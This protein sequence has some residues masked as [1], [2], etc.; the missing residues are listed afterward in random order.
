MPS[1]GAGSC[2]GGLRAAARAAL[3]RAFGVAGALA[4]AVA[5]AALAALAAATAPPAGA[6]ELPAGSFVFDGSVDAVA[7]ADGHTYLGGAFGSQRAATGAGVVVAAGGDGAVAPASFPHVEGTVSA[8]IPDGAGGWY[9]GGRFTRVGGIARHNLA[10]ITVTGAVD[11]GWRPVADAV[12][13]DLALAGGRVY[14]AGGFSAVDD[15]ARAGLAAVDAD[16]GAVADWAPRLATRGYA[17]GSSAP[18]SA[19]AASATTVY[20]SGAFRAVDGAERSGGL[21]AFDAADGA[22]EPWAPR[23]DAFEG[24][25]ALAV[26]DGRLYAAGSFTTVDGVARAG[27]AAFD[28]ATGELSPWDPRLAGA[29]IAPP[30]D[31]P[32]DPPAGDAPLADPPLTTGVVVPTLAV[33][34]GTVYVAGSFA[35][36]GDDPRA[37]LAAIDAASGE[38]TAWQPT[39]G[40]QGV[41]ALAAA[42]GVVYLAGA[43]GTVDGAERV[44]AAAVDGAGGALLPWDPQLLGD[45]ATVAV[46][47]GRVYL[48]GTIAGAGPPLAQVANLA[49]LDGDGALDADWRPQPDGAVT[50]L[51]SGGGRLY[52]AGAFATIGGAARA[53][54]AALDP[55]TGAAAAWDPAPDGPVQALLPA[56]DRVYLAGDF[57]TVGGAVRDGL[58]AVA[59][60]SG[61]AA[62]WQPP[63]P[64]DGGEPGVVSQLA[65]GDGVV[66]V[67][68]RF[69]R[70]GDAARTDV[71]A[72]DAASGAPTAWDARIEQPAGG[73]R[74][75]L[76]SLAADDGAV[77][78]AGDFARLGDG[79]ERPGL[80]ALDTATGAPTAWEPSPEASASDEVPGMSFPP[81]ARPQTLALAGDALYLA[82]PRVVVR[83]GWWGVETR[84][85]ALDR[86]TGAV[87]AWHPG[88]VVPTSSSALLAVA[89][90]R[91][92]IAATTFSPVA[93]TTAASVALVERAPTA[94]TTPPRATVQRPQPGE[95]F[96]RGAVVDAEVACD[97]QGGTPLVACAA[98][99]RVDTAVSGPHRF[100]VTAQNAAG[101]AIQ[102]AVAYEVEPP[103][104]AGGPWGPAAA[105][106]APGELGAQPQVAADDAGR[107]TALYLA[108]AARPG[109]GV[110]ATGTVRVADRQASGAWAEPATLSGG[111]PASDPALAAGSGG[112]RVAAWV[113]HDGGG[114]T[115]RAARAGATGAWSAPASLGSGAGTVS[116]V[117]AVVDGDG[118]A[119]VVWSRQVDTH[120]WAVEAATA[121]PD[122]GWTGPATI[123]AGDANMTRGP[124]V[125]VAADGAVTAVWT[126]AGTV[127]AATRAGAASP[128]SAP[129]QVGDGDFGAGGG[130]NLWPSLAV[131]PDGRA[132]AVWTRMSGGEQTIVAARRDGDGGWEA[133]APLWQG[134]ASSFAEHRAVLAPDGEATALLLVQELV[135]IPPTPVGA[136]LLATSRAAG[137]T[138]W[139]APA[140][141]ASEPTLA[142][143]AL[144][145]AADGTVT[146]LWT[147][148]PTGPVFQSARR[149]P[150]GTWQETIAAIAGVYDRADPLALAVAPNGGETAVWV[151]GG[152][153][154]GEVRAAVRGSAPPVDT[155]PPVT[156]IDA[157]PEGMVEV[158][159]VTF[160]FSADE[161]DA[162]F[163]CAREGGPFEP[164][165]SPLTLTGLPDGDHRIAIRATDRAGN[166]EQP[167]LRRDYVIEAVPPETEQGDGPPASTRATDATFRFA[168]SERPARFECS[169]DGAPFAAC[170]P[171]ATVAGLAD[172]EHLFR[173]RAVDRADKRDPSPAS[174]AFTV[175]TVAPQVVAIDGPEGFVADPRPTLRFTADEPV[176]TWE[177][178]VDDGPAAPC[179]EAFTTPALA[180]GEHVVRV[181][182]TDAAGNVGPF[183]ASE[184]FTVD[185]VPPRTTVTGAPAELIALDHAEIAFVADEP[186]TFACAVDGRTAPC[187]P[188]L[189]LSGL[190]DGA[191]RVAVTATDRAGNREPTAALVDFTVDTTPPRVTIASQPPAF[192]A[193]DDAEVAFAADE[194]ARFDCALD[195][196]A[197]QPCSSPARWEAL[198]DGPHVVAVSAVDRAGNAS[199]GAREAAF[200]VDTVAPETTIDVRPDGPVRDRVARFEFSSDE[201]GATFRCA[202][203]E[204]A[205]E[206]CTSP[207]SRTLV[208]DGE[209]RFAVH[210]VDRAGNADPSP[211]TATFLLDTPNSP[212]S[213]TLTLDRDRGTT[214]LHVRATV[215]ASDAD[216]DDALTY[217]LSF[218]DGSEVASGTLPAEPVEH[219]YERAGAFRVEL[220][221]SD[222]EA[223]VV[224]SARVEVAADEPLAAAAGDD[225]RAVVGQAVSFDAGGSRPRLAF[226]RFAWEFGDG[227]T[228][229]G[230]RAEHAWASPG[231]YTVRLRASAGAETVADTAVV[232]VAPAPPDD[233]LRVRVSDGGAPLAG[234]SAVW[235]A[236]DGSRQSAVSG[237]DGVARLRGLPD[238]A[239]TVYVAAAGFAPRALSAT[240][241]DG[242]GELDAALERGA[243]GAATL[244]ARRMS[245]EE[246]VAAG[247]DVADPDNSHVYEAN[248]W[249][250]FEP[251]RPLHVYVAPG[252]V[253]CASDC[254]GG[255]GGGGASGHRWGCQTAAG[256]TCLI[257]GSGSSRRR[258][259]P[260]V[261]YVA[262][263]PVVYWLVLPMRASFLKEFFDVQMV[264]HNLTGGF[265]FAPGVASLQLPRGLSLA[266]LAEPQSVAQPV[267]AIPSGE[268]RT[269]SWLVRGDVEGDYDLDAA[270][271]STLD[272]S[273]LPV[274]LRASTQEPLRVWA[275]AALRTRIV[276]DCSAVRWAPYQV[277]VE[278]ENV[279]GA[280]GEQDAAPVYNLQVELFDRPDDAPDEQALFFYGPGTETTQGVDVLEPGGRW[281]ASFVVYAGIGNSEI[282]R[283]TTNLRRSFVQRTGGDVD[284]E[285]TIARRC[286]GEDDDTSLGPRSGAVSAR[287]VKAGAH[288]AIEVRW[289]RTPADSLPAGATVT[290]YELWA[291]QGLDGGSWDLYRTVPSSGDETQLLGI[292]A[293]DRAIGRYVTVVTRTADGRRHS[294]HTVAT[295]PARYVSLGDSYSS[296]EGVPAFEP[297][298]AKDVEAVG[299]DRPDN[300]CHRSWQG[301]Y[302]RL[303]VADRSIQ[304]NLQPAA[305]AACSGAVTRDFDDPDGN[306]ERDGEPAQIAHVSEF[307]NL[308]TLSVG[309]NDV[310]FSD[311]AAICLLMRCDSTL[312]ALDAIGSQQWLE[313]LGD[314]WTA[315][316]VYGQ[317]IADVLAAGE[318]CGNLADVVG[319]LLCAYRARKA[320]RSLEEAWN[321][322]P[323]RVATP[324]NL[325]NGKLRERLVRIYRALGEEAPNARVL[326]QPYPQIVDTAR[327]ERTC[328]LLPGFPLTLTGGDRVGIARVIGRLNEQIE[329]AVA[330]ANEAL[331]RPQFAV[332][333]PAP[334]FSG[335]ELC[336]D[337]ELNPESHFNSFVNPF[338]S[339]PGNYGP[340]SYSFH[341][342]AGGQAAYARAA[343]AALAGDLTGQVARVG[344]HAHT[345]A[346]TVFVPRGARTLTAR[347]SWQGST[348]RMTLVSPG[349]A[350]VD[351]DTPGVT[352][353]GS[354]VSEELTVT[355]PQSGEWEVRLYGEEVPDGGELTEVT[356]FADAPAAP[357]PEVAVT[358]R[359]VSGHA[360]LF[361]FA[362]AAGA[363][364]GIAFRWSFSD[365]ATSDGPTVRHAFAGDGGQ[366][367]T[368]EAVPGDG[369]ASGWATVRLGAP[370]RTPPEVA[371]SAPV[372]GRDLRDARPQIAGTAGVATEGEGRAADLARVEVAL[373]AGGE[374]VGDPLLSLTAARDG[375]GRWQVAPDAPLPDGTYTVRASQRDDAGN[376]GRSAPRSFRLDATAPTVAIVA[377][378]AGATTDG[379]PAFA[380]TA[381]AE[382]G[383][384]PARVADGDVVRVELFAGDA[385]AGPLVRTLEAPRAADGAW[386]AAIPADAP[387]PAGRYTARA[388]QSDA[389]GNAGSATV[390]FTVAAPGSGGDGGGSGG[391]D[392]SGGDAGSGGGPGGDGGSGGGAGGGGGSGGGGA[393]GGGSGGGGGDGSGGGGAGGGDGS[394]GAGGDGSGGRAGGRDGAGRGGDRSGRSGQGGADGAG[395]GGP[396]RA[397][398]LTPAAG[399]AT[400]RDGR[401]FALPLR[402]A[403]RA[404]C[405][406]RVVVYATVRASGR[407]RRG[408]GIR[409]VAIGRARATVAGGRRARV[410]IR[411]TARGRALLRRRGRLRT[412]LSIAMPGRRTRAARLVVRWHPSA[413]RSPRAAAR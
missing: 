383:D 24:A 115:V 379:A 139:S 399:V 9:V 118:V 233:G 232:T 177:C 321:F 193:D 156:T 360:Q 374:A 202:L 310:G 338:L 72:L 277:D 262:G 273:G 86:A 344:P 201:P 56:A 85:L 366:W 167:P 365:G 221:V 145:A 236:P 388:A 214:P 47:G 151:S 33:A 270:Y 158:S 164:C 18:V 103:A 288:D 1:I 2:R 15:R 198:A 391:G 279:T 30:V 240:V 27:L 284:L 311:I 74:S 35:T 102:Q 223:T 362:A 166:R 397:A 357:A 250:N 73:W 8:A 207:Y 340:V 143:P 97:P 209:H 208:H 195:G 44:G 298:T 122:G 290:G 190:A 50:R 363:E 400:V 94:A 4:V 146:A 373:W 216:P 329:Q 185:T 378:A 239:Q 196:A 161:P 215:A 300:T 330:E 296:G 411:L 278:F 306:P 258:I 238:G 325:F 23:L 393:G 104:A 172:G 96:E 242:A 59:A 324:L 395:G 100:T 63:R 45:A 384:D 336:R 83:D 345:R 75:G 341:P 38:A 371:L 200:T 249:L 212:P 286:S 48:G 231:V 131:A 157:G 124:A 264:V 159:T 90:G 293:K 252:G 60:D 308:V 367:A 376:E 7:H 331:G 10:R 343:A 369:G 91:L 312:E 87:A 173:A 13:T 126:F 269:V 199:D 95:R 333:D 40:G 398:P 92:A 138:A 281:T 361:D 149:T 182:A 186:A 113:E 220:S 135:G 125:G 261:D 148:G 354:A 229:E 244:D 128:W 76:T 69:D 267:A 271:S 20:V 127:R 297:G 255:G 254:G 153:P 225:R 348:V 179:G 227:A 178:A 359:R 3:A 43:F 358:T 234:A 265:S 403:G 93:F 203:D 276:V 32:V 181:R 134:S 98:P 364:D 25:Q 241:R 51:A 152:I 117:R 275:G 78:V 303:L 120:E 316:S 413:A 405:A 394:G 28:A 81:A 205:P 406:A 142:A 283:L 410:T 351:R 160:A 22:L 101:I 137:A 409:R 305:F 386:S 116:G 188:P 109:P 320:I 175:D 259:Y 106:S 183:A 315:G 99:A 385:A 19:L 144:G 136:R 228:A 253:F 6:A 294:L 80:A 251:E 282:T 285:P 213:A 349:G 206:P 62:A 335:H 67:G 299:G 121:R 266:P 11:P 263:E 26:A 322:D 301:A 140:T 194:E 21:A 64:T 110:E 169:L 79:V 342:N 31:P 309:G 389:V 268:S 402:C 226:D 401:S 295:G 390:T 37:G 412:T 107:A 319:K 318:Q 132:L 14:L 396:G 89:G 302:G 224:R 84:L 39:V 272:P 356:A 61:A 219:V 307:T 347:S 42:G 119:T 377:P 168:S 52:A 260:H 111:A 210:A 123:G 105:I 314:M 46:A 129:Q 165:S 191:H 189:A 280:A 407:G 328:E 162:T 381:G 317:A 408:R 287:V 274:Y 70:V 237:A 12:V 247:I 211:A 243:V 54:L 170:E 337:G 217:R 71:A 184:R 192:T 5:V 327:Q 257:A 112:E 176:E 68:G 82:A 49:R 133:P 150:D 256:F 130:A 350:L 171:P 187:E 155:R 370:D 197:P 339:N 332:T 154:E 387:L 235:V 245:Y 66:Y 204:G 375:D 34:D 41:R 16:S 141:V 346:G 368:V 174:W 291:R 382:R 55:E 163:E 304:A 180:D 53:G 88:L 323:E 147:S 313:R 248:I 353:G 246:I 355:D 392:G 108:L 29:P 380:G 326:V 57:S 17:S 58:A 222:G 334:W 372:A 218:G 289:P 77:Y 292:P 36:V 230:E 65:L 352:V 114:E 404:R